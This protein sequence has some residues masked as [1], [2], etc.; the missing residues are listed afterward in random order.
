M[1]INTFLILYIYLFSILQNNIESV[2]TEEEQKRVI[3]ILE[4]AHAMMRKKCNKLPTTSKKKC[5]RDICNI[6]I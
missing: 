1:R 2:L 5:Y 3:N 4:K 6:N